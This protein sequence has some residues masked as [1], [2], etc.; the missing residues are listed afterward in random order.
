[1]ESQRPLTKFQQRVKN[2]KTSLLLPGAIGNIASLYLFR[3]LDK[4]EKIGIIGLLNYPLIG[5]MGWLNF[6]FDLESLPSNKRVAIMILPYSKIKNVSPSKS[7]IIFLPKI[8]GIPDSFTFDGSV[9]SGKLYVLDP[10]NDK[11]Y[12]SADILAQDLINDRI[13]EMKYVFE[14][15]GATKLDI[16]YQGSEDSRES[17][18]FDSSN[19]LSGTYKIFGL[20]HSSRELESSSRIASKYYQ[21]EIHKRL[22][23][24]K[25]PIDW[26]SLYWY[27]S[28]GV[29]Q[30]EVK[31]ILDGLTSQVSFKTVMR[32]YSSQGSSSLTTVKQDLSILN[33]LGLS[34]EYQEAEKMLSELSKSTIWEVNVEF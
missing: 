23:G 6:L 2:I 11:K 34:R 24:K 31:S 27:N 12:C 13:L 28:D 15:L 7:G 30:N 10:R 20:N 25:L 22:T 33:T 29:L 4:S 1:M 32:S 3:K 18:D 5:A 21:F 26:N 16:S 14:R 8:I 9:E 17:R 19:D